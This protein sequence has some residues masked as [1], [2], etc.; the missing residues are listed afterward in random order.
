MCGEGGEYETLTLDC[1]LFTQGRILLDAW[2][3]VTVSNDSMAP[4]ALLHPKTFHVE[5]K[6]FQ[7]LSSLPNEA[8]PAS[9]EPVIV[10]VP[11]DFLAPASGQNMLS[12]GNSGTSGDQGKAPCDVRTIRSLGTACVSLT[13]EVSGS[14]ELYA[15]T[16]ESTTQALTSALQ[17]ISRELSNLNLTWQDALFVHLYVPAMAHFAAANAAY[18]NF[19]PPI[20]PPS[21]ATVQ[22]ALNPSIALVAEV[23]LRRS[24][25]S[26]SSPL[27]DGSDATPSSY[28]RPNLH[29]KKVL[30]VQSISEWAPSCIGPYSQAVSHQGLVFF[31]G[32]IPLDP[33]TMAVATS[34]PAAATARSL[35]SC[36]A[37]AIAMQTDLRYGSLWWTVYCSAA[38]GGTGRKA[39]GTTLQAFLRNTL[40][41]DQHLSSL[42]EKSPTSRLLEN[43]V[44][45]R[46]I[47]NSDEEEEEEEEEFVDSYLLPPLMHR[48]WE[49]LV[50]YIEMP[51]LPR[52]VVVE[53][54]PVAWSH[55]G[56][57]Q[58]ESFSSSSSDSSNNNDTSPTSGSFNAV[59]SAR[60]GPRWIA[61]MDVREEL[62]EIPA[63]R[64]E[65][66]LLCSPGTIFRGSA[67]V[68]SA[69]NEVDTGICEVAGVATQALRQKMEA[70][71]LGTADVVAVKVYVPMRESSSSGGGAGADF[72]D[73]V[74][75]KVET[76]L[77]VESIVVVVPVLRVGS[78]PSA[79]ALLGIE[80]FARK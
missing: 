43:K 10:Q 21:R 2:D 63:G 18:S 39:A 26:S 38:A 61:M 12:E 11:D 34:D 69:A 54:Q 41:D 14:S 51:E 4:V 37:V 22:L 57:A 27:A 70:G 64:A 36:Q 79:S 62:V 55:H 5:P 45:A 50:T 60:E 13:A 16:A 77:E 1:P 75:K 7:S 49:P 56:T 80:V 73:G 76:I 25:D 59:E 31:A 72:L 68:I 46:D 20:N 35:R 58:E 29:E 78:D 24:T 44:A 19:F 28:F 15:T 9:K 74:R 42:S 32:Q 33:P 52:G 17:A 71:L 8:T 48:H 23:L 40:T 3:T 47:N 6:K 66:H 53:V 30:H 65:L 67:F